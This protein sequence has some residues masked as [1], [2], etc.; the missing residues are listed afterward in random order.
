MR[1]ASEGRWTRDHPIRFDEARELALPVSDE[2]PEEA[3]KF[4]RHYRQRARWPSVGYRTTVTSAIHDF[5][6][7]LTSEI[8]G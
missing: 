2:L 3:H 7:P 5:K 8:N 1:Q 6:S 4:M